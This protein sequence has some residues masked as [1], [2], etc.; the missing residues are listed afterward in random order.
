MT[1]LGLNGDLGGHTGDH[2]GLSGNGAVL[3]LFQGNGNGTHDAILIEAEILGN[4]GEIGTVLL[5]IEVPVA[6]QIGVGAGEVVGG[7][8]CGVDEHK[9]VL[10]G[11]G[12]QPQ[13]LHVIPGN[14][15]LQVVTL[16]L[17]GVHLA[18]LGGGAQNGHDVAGGGHI[19]VAV[20]TVAS[21]EHHVAG[22]QQVDLKDIAFLHGGDMGGSKVQ[23][24]TAV[25]IGLAIQIDEDRHALG[26]I[27]H[28]VHTLFAIVAGHGNVDIVAAVIIVQIQPVVILIDLFVQDT[29]NDDAGVGLGLGFLRI[30]VGI[31]FLRRCFLKSTLRS[32]LICAAAG[33]HHNRKDQQKEQTFQC[34][35]SLLHCEPSLFT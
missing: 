5:G 7:D 10:H 13:P 21:L 6:V 11:I 2:G 20:L 14:K 24:D 23:L 3:A 35:I 26:Y 1:G 30:G 31:V 22:G 9:A 32:R 15:Q 8:V 27:E 16:A 33:K 34:E 18:A 28:E 25:H 29:V 19:G 4:L 12:I 17:R